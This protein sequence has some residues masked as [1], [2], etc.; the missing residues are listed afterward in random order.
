MW[1]IYLYSLE[2][3]KIPFNIYSF[4]WAVG[5]DFSDVVSPYAISSVERNKRQHICF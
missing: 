3:S 1:R 5:F 2:L 4:H